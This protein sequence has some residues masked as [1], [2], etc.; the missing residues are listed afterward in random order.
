M[1]NTQKESLVLEEAIVA[2]EMGAVA[3]VTTVTVKDILQ[4]IAVSLVVMEEV[5]VVVAAAVVAV[6]VVVLAQGKKNF[7]LR[8]FL[9]NRF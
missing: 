1:L 3:H 9:K 2:L 4:E 8:I 6:H 5:A 7:S